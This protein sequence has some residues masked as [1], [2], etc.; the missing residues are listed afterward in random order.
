MAGGER[1]GPKGRPYKA[2]GA[3][4]GASAGLGGPNAG[5]SPSSGSAWD[6]FRYRA[7]AVQSIPFRYRNPLESAHQSIP[8]PAP[9]VQNQLY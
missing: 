4:A 8:R 5:E 9:V 3:V 2:L 6:L 1:K 7:L